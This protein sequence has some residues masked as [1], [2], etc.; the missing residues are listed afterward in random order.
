MAGITQQIPSFIQGISE[1]PDF[2]KVPG[3]VV[4]LKN[5]LPDVTR[6]LIKRPG[7]QLVSSITPSSGTLSWF[8][9]YT[10]DENQYIGNV[11]TSGVVQIWR[12][13]DGAVIPIDYSA[14][15]GTSACTY[16]SGWTNADELQALTV[17][18]ST[19]IA[20]RNTTVAMKTATSDKSPV[21]LLLLKFNG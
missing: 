7:G 19:F 3:Q 10:D 12:T 11:N 13:S 6:G 4:D 14:V 2:M 1:Q 20:N 15:P 17:N 16:L 5:G 18:E 9:I 8:H 21:I